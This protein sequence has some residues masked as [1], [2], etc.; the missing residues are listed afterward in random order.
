MRRSVNFLIFT[1]IITIF[2][3]MI[4]AQSNPLDKLIDK[5]S[6]KDGFRYIEMETNILNF[7][8]KESNPESDVK[9]IYFGQDSTTKFDISLIY[10][11]FTSRIK[12]RD[13][14]DIAVVFMK[15]TKAELLIKREGSEISGLIVILKKKGH[16]MIFG[17]SG[18]FDLNDLSRLK[19]LKD[20]KG[21]KMFKKF[22]EH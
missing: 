1:A 21:L 9:V 2:P 4:W 16:L 11:K 8:E 13:F 18:I 3:G 15:G 6:G 12:S 22:C 17:A 20:W 14:E 19:E 10:D 5:Y 7:S